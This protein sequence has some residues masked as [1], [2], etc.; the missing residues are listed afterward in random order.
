MHELCKWNGWLRAFHTGTPP[1]QTR[2]L[3]VNTS[4][5]LPTP[6]PACISCQSGPGFATA[7]MGVWC[8]QK[9]RFEWL[10]Q[11]RMQGSLHVIPCGDS[12][13]KC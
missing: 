8:R 4:I 13:Q 12:S 10:M 7:R 3:G 11:R 9:G 6:A 1:T 5:E 2:C